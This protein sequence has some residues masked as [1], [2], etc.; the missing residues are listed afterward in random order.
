MPECPGCHGTEVVKNGR[1]HGKQRFKCPQCGRQFV[2]HPSKKV[3]DAATRALIDRLLLERISLAGITRAA[4]GSE[5]W[6]QDSEIRRCSASSAGIAQKKGRLTLQCDELG[7][8]VG[9]KHHQQW[10]WLALDTT[11]RAIVGVC[12]CPR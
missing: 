2:E 3:I 6:V 9:R 1:I 11:T 12:G 4:Q 7:S 8:F 10:V 5:P